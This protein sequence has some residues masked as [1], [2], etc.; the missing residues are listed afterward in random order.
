MKKLILFVST[1]FIALSMS[2]QTIVNG[3]QFKDRILP[4]QGSVTK[5]AEQAI[6]GQEGVQGRFLD[7]GA[8]PASTTDGKP[9]LSYW[10][11]NIMKDANSIYHLYLAGWDA[12]QR[13]HSYWS[14]SDIYHL[15]STSPQGPFNLTE[16]SCLSTSVITAQTSTPA[17]CA[18]ST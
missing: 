1:T 8:E 3:G 9:T 5:S 2:A 13:A 4:M 18:A 12:T 11:G 7:N 15:T 14:R 16:K 17:A 10:G 6:W